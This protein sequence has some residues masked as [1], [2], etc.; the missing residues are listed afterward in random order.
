MSNNY[1]KPMPGV[2]V[3]QSL[4]DVKAGLNFTTSGDLN[5]GGSDFGRFSVYSGNTGLHIG[6]TTP[7]AGRGGVKLP[8]S[9]GLDGKPSSAW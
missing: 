5:I 8:T 9:V 1:I 6:N 2:N 4:G 3:G 7:S